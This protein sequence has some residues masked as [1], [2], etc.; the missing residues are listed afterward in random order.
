MYR[1]VV[2]DLTGQLRHDM[3]LVLLVGKTPAQCVQVVR[4]NVY[5]VDKELIAAVFIK[6]RFFEVILLYLLLCLNFCLFCTKIYIY[7]YLYSRY[8]FRR[9]LNSFNID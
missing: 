4:I 5:N 1:P 6:R 3:F 7:I 9:A 8:I 2:I